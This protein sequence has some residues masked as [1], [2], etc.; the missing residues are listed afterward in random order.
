[1]SQEN[2]F[3]PNQQDYKPLSPFHL[4][5]KSNFPFIENT[6]EALDNYGLYC[7]VVEYLNTVI[8]NENT[9]ED[10]VSALYDAFVSLNTYVSDYF[11]N[12][13]V[14]EE[15]NKKLDEMAE[16]GRLT[17]L[18]YQYI[19]PVFN[20]QDAKINNIDRK[21]DSLS[22]GAPIPVS[23]T[24]D[25][26]DTTKVYLLTT[27]GYWYYY[28][29]A[30]I[31]GGIYQ[32]S[33]SINQVNVNEEMIKNIYNLESF[34]GNIFEFENITINS[35]TGVETSSQTRITSDYIYDNLLSISIS[36]GYS[37][38]L[39]VYNSGGT[40]KGIY[41]TGT[42]TIEPSSGLTW[43]ENA[44]DIPYDLLSEG[45]KIRIAI[46]KK[47]NSVIDT[48]D[49]NKINFSYKLL[50]DYN[51]TSEKEINLNNL[52][53]Y[54]DLDAFVFD[55]DFT[56]SNPINIYK[57]GN[58][59]TTNLDVSDLKNELTDYVYISPEGNDITGDGSELNPY[60]TFEQALSENTSTIYLLEGTYYLGDNFQN[61]I[62][63]NRNLNIISKN[64]VLF[65]GDKT[66]KLLNPDGI[67][68]FRANV[69][70]EG[71]TFNGGRGLIVEVTNT[72]PC[73]N[74]CKFINSTQNGL[75]FRGVGCYVI[76]CEAYNN[77]LDGF[78]YH[79]YG[80]YNPTGVIEINS[81]SYNN[82]NVNNRSSNGSTIHNNGRIIRLKC[83]YYNNHGGNLAD[84]ESLS[85]NF[86]CNSY[87]SKN[88]NQT[89]IYY[90]A[91]YNSLTSSKIWLYNCMGSNSIYQLSALQ[92][93][94]IN[95]DTRIIPNYV[96]K[97]ST[98]Q[99]NYI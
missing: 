53:E 56:H 1:M 8:E 84:S 6:F 68:R 87:S 66:T 40:F 38:L 7:K 72:Y 28:N 71:I 83:E 60:Y 49:S 26:I 14:Q 80:I 90:N 74:K 95:C 52:Y 62:L 19:I 10:N 54:D 37:I 11:D 31:Q 12:L 47:D 88:Y 20:E 4:F 30:W 33:Q 9:V 98:S 85:Y 22:S 45:D 13:D 41:R 17:E 70:C 43:T 64:A 23:S 57:I 69:Y 92:N 44:L 63:I 55:N 65:F 2:N 27:T 81:K 77:E 35:V 46:R 48:T 79:S 61:G 82:G 78:N 3:V 89:D 42:H 76:N 91:N 73:F 51:R 21:V 75:N 94:T 96:Y 25:M 29:D 36:S 93:S 16:D 32:S 34:N 18:L 58:Q 99:I 86:D 59:Y 5:V 15:I 50:N 67:M 97:D 24:S 39:Y